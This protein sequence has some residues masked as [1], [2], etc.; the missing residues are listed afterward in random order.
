MPALFS[1]DAGVVAA[2]TAPRKTASP[3]VFLTAPVGAETIRD[4]VG[5]KGWPCGQ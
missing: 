3:V 2:A 5:R 1:F 4:I